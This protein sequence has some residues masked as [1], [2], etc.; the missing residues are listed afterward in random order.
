[1]G[2]F[3]DTL[4]RV[5]E[6]V[7][8]ISLTGGEP[9]HTPYLVDDAVGAIADVFRNGEEIDLVTNGFQFDNILKGET[10]S[11]LSAPPCTKAHLK[12]A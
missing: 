12:T 10:I 9:M 6:H 7:Y 4:N 5:R 3:Q 1:M 2:T 8:G 11:G